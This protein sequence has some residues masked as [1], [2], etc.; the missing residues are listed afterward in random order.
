MKTAE[1]A[2]PALST[3]APS[4]SPRGKGSIPVLRQSLAAAEG[5]I[6]KTVDL[7]R[8]IKLFE[9]PYTRYLNDKL[10]NAVKNVIKHLQKGILLKDLVQ[11]F[12]ILNEC[13]E[14]IKYHA[15]FIEPTCEI[16]KIYGLP[17]LKEKSSDETKYAKVVSESILQLGSLMK[18]P[19]FQVR[20]QICS[21]FINFY[22][23]ER[24]KQKNEGF[25][26]TNSDY[27]IRMAESAGLAET[28]VLFLPSLE[29]L[30]EEKIWL[31]KTLQILSS[32]SVINCNLMIKAQGANMICSHLNDPDPSGQLLFRSSEIL[33]NLLEKGDSK[34]ETVKQLNNLECIKPLKEAFVNLLIN[35]YRHFDHQLRN[36]LLVIS[37][38]IAENPGTLMIESGFAKQLILFATYCE[39]KSHSPL[40]RSLKLSFNHE[41]F[42]MKKLLFNM[43]VI[44]AKDL[45][46]VQL[47]SDGRVILALFHY[48]KP[49][50]SPGAHNWP[51]AH[52]EDL[53]LHAIAA[54]ASVA[55]L[56][57]EDY[58]TCQGN[59]RLLLF[60]EW[61]VGQDPF[62]SHGNC[63]H[64]S[65]G[66]GNKRAQMRY[67]LR[68][69]R[70]MVS[71]GDEA[72]NQ[73]LCDQGA[74][75]QLLG[76][77]KNIISRTDDKED[78]VILEIKADILFILSAVCENDLHTKDLFGFE[79]VE[80]L[81]MLL[82]MDPVLYNSGVGHNRLIL[83]TL[84]SIWCCV[85]GC[86]AS[87]DYFLEKEGMFIL[88]DLLALNQKNMNSLILGIVVEFSENPK[89]IA[90]LMTWRGQKEQS[91]GNLLIQLWRQEEQALNVRRDE[92]DRIV[93]AKQPLVG[94]LQAQQEVI[95]MPAN[96]PS[97]AIMDVAENMRANIYSILYRLGFEDL[98][99][100]AAKDLVTVSVISKYFDL[101]VGEIWNEICAEL[102]AE[103]F[104]PVTPDENAL[105]VIIKAS[106]DVGKTVATHQ[107]EMLE[108][109]QKLDLQEEQQL[110]TNMKENHKQNDLM[111]K[112]WNN[113]L[114]RTSNFEALKKAKKLQ[115]KSIESSR[116]KRPKQRATFHTTQIKNLH[117]TVPCGPLV[118]IHSTPE[119]TGG[120]LANAD[121]AVRKVAVH[122]GPLQKVKSVKMLGLN[123]D[124]VSVK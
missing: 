62:F 4:G 34:D 82:K 96:C 88:L 98:P 99:Y 24:P 66:R 28:L 59:T 104:R 63:F 42:E 50:E 10:L 33:W 18:V 25:Q 92:N 108:N 45:S 97:I 76:I 19:C 101:K 72:V 20:R 27:K 67:S 6:L 86:Y 117:T 80:V 78:A 22:S 85:I 13:A 14:K 94:S 17:F 64:G 112:S 109:H 3:A 15:E 120:S 77:L 11:V 47:L 118:T 2:V 60:L 8:V 48:V 5:D 35:G 61:C 116:V 68:L 105:D 73:D 71:L 111:V 26:S 57:V 31:L 84:D 56:L 102:T 83:G 113:F 43:M 39:V 95:P 115:E 75:S 65:G 36:D 90:H 93:D 49:N 124:S 87:E 44:L 9:D 30:L 91:I 110:Y 106:E 103:G 119:L 74:I 70:S 37:T 114:T 107:T 54:L 1:L 38:L 7:N 55:P 32:S 81:L 123:T 69:L 46:T 23:T 58:M 53:Q 12:Q 51:A 16:I 122:G 21:S 79:G 121:L 52:F 29:N 89:S 40:V 100:L 41:D